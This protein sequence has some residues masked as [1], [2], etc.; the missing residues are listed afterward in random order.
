MK[1]SLIVPG[2][3]LPDYSL[4]ESKAFLKIIDVTKTDSMYFGI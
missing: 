3:L 2:S 1:I 4:H